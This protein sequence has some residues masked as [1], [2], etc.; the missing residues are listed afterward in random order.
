M[1]FFMSSCSITQEI[2]MAE[3]GRVSYAT[4]VDASQLASMGTLPKEEDLPLDTVMSFRE[5]VSEKKD[6]E[7][8]PEEERQYFNDFADMSVSV[9]NDPEKKELFIKIFGD[10]EDIAALNRALRAM[11]MME[12]KNKK[13]SSSGKMTEIDDLLA[14]YSDYKWDG[15]TF[16]V[17][18]QFDENAEADRK[19]N[20]EDE[21][22]KSLNMFMGGKMRTKYTFPR[23]IVNVNHPDALFS[24]DRKTVTIEYPAE[25]Y[26][27]QPRITDIVIELED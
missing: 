12:I 8:M 15:K 2:I 4:I 3:D 21:V 7:E 19:N 25:E 6:I 22:S 20:E 5:I 10:F 17:I 23:K 11:Y 13:S 26:I 9:H 1:I 14:R 27:S 18:S 24:D 16:S